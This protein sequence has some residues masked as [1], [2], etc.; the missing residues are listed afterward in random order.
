MKEEF[1]IMPDKPPFWRNKRFYGSERHEIFEGYVTKNR[2]YSIEDGLVIFITPEQ[3]R[4]GK[5]SIHKNPKYW[6][7]EIK[8]QEIAE[9]VWIDYYG[10]TKDDFRLRYGKNYL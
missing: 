3:H 1:S 6:R 2:N 4:F 9:E 8:I 7:E 5:N 10:K